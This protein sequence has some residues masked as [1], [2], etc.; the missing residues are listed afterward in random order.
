MML[1]TLFL[2]FVLSVFARAQ[3]L[4]EII[5]YTLDNHNSLRAIEQKL[6]SFD[7][8][9]S[10][11][12]KFQ[13]PELSLSVG[14]IQF[15]DVTNRSIEP[16]QYQ[17]INLKQKIPYFGK[18]DAAYSN[19]LA[20][21]EIVFAS[22]QEAKVALVKEIKLSA[23]TIWEYEQKLLL[24]DESMEL[25]KK[26]IEL[27]NI[28]VSNAGEGWHM[29]MS[30]LELEHSEL[31]I[32]KHSLQSELRQL[33]ARLSYLSAM[34]VNSLDVSVS[35]KEPLSLESYLQELPNNK[36][37]LKKA[38]QIEEKNSF[39][40]VKELDAN[41]DP[42]ISIGYFQ[43]ESFE[44]YV[45]VS[46][47]AA[48]PVYGSESL[49]AQK[50]RKEVLEATNV[51]EDFSESLKAAI[52]QEYAKLTNAYEIYKIITNESLV[53]IEHMLELADASVKNGQTLVLYT[54]LLQKRVALHE[55][56]R[57]AE[58]SFQ[59][60]QTNLEALRGEIQ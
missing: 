41:I 49:N 22:L 36:T 59:R 47:G 39:A 40:K 34:E 2:L 18:R 4:D 9:L 55:K 19:V 42:F 16:M 52:I 31:K 43:R 13:N 35:M 58:A 26:N 24:V 46:V 17:S 1:R 6:S 37:Y 53:E 14:D 48:L 29:E 27:S 25:V 3:S 32:K 21:K 15:K 7:E 30:S 10:L 20:N 50:A 33:Y 54:K 51:R 57:V 11:T 60:A 28:Y 8:T 56:Q 23:Y 5:T 38:A 44:D 45:S 12:Q